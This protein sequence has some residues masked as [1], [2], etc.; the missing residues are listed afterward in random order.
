MTRASLCALL[1]ALAACGGPTRPQPAPAPPPQPA[2]AAPEE[3][4]FS[5]S[6]RVLSE[7]DEEV[8]VTVSTVVP[9][10]HGMEKDLPQQRLSQTVKPGGAFRFEGLKPGA[11]WVSAASPWADHSVTVTADVADYE[12]RLGRPC[13]LLGHVTFGDGI[14]PKD[15]W[16]RYDIA[17]GGY[18]LGRGLPRSGRFEVPGL[19]AGP[20]GVLVRHW[21]D[22]GPDG[23]EPALRVESYVK[24][25]LVPGDNEVEIR[26][27]ASSPRAK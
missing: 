20:V 16:V 15:C 23:A 18:E 4:A 6:G 1:L 21:P 27:D 19:P 17:T 13:K 9:W 24:A 3:K 7:V 25:T 26:I 12:I 11:F 14:E 5:L 2:P 8:V 22:R 10:L